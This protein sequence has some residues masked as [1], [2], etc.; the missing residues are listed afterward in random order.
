[1][2]VANAVVPLWHAPQNDPVHPMRELRSWK[3]PCSHSRRIALH[4][5]RR[6]P[7]LRPDL[8]R[9]PQMHRP[10]QLRL[11]SVRRHL[12]P[13]VTPLTRRRWV[14]RHLPVTLPAV[15]PLQH[16]R[17]RDLHSP[18][19]ED[20]RVA[21]T[22]I[23]QLRV[24]RVREVRVEHLVRARQV[25]VEL[26]LER[27]PSPRTRSVHSVPRSDHFR[28]LRLHPVHVPRM[29]PR[30]KLQHRIRVQRLLGLRH[31][32][33]FRHKQVLRYLSPL[34]H[35][36]R[37]RHPARIRHP[38]IHSLPLFFG[39]GHVEQ[40]ANETAVARRVGNAHRRHG[41]DEK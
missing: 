7:A 6:V 23:H 34:Q 31:H 28:P 27:V 4:H 15:P 9:T 39:G 20:P 41:G 35:N 36:P 40:D 38:R 17:H 18:R 1:M 32:R 25:E 29:V 33:V 16:V 14:E 8:R 12:H 37:S 10:D 11:R 2:V 21:L 13:R 22:T 30:Q 26:E 19:L 24:R 3:C 5:P